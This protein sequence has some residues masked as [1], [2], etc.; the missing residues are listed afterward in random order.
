MAQAEQQKSHFY[1][2]VDMDV[3][4][5]ENELDAQYAE[6]SMQLRMQNQQQRAA[7]EMQAMQLTMEYQQRKSEEDMLKQQLA[8]ERR[9]SEIQQQIQ[10]EMHRLA[11]ST[12][13]GQQ[14]VQLNMP[15]GLPNPLSQQPFPQQQFP[16]MS[17]LNVSK[18][19]FRG[20]FQMSSR[21]STM[22]SQAMSSMAFSLPSVSTNRGSFCGGN[23]GNGMPMSNTQPPHGATTYVYGP[24]GQLIPKN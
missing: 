2:Q 5:Q 20:S 4:Q 11:G 7:L 13:N 8:V 6:Q 19:M 15:N 18:N 17:G 9:Q 12:P 23:V 3:R 22:G 10:N 1:T 21:M 16:S 14:H 24:N